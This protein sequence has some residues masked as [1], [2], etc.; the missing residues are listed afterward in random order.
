MLA[1]LGTALLMGIMLDSLTGLIPVFSL[2]F[3][4]PILIS[5]IVYKFGWIK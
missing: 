3:T 5:R 4:L 2:S 1:T